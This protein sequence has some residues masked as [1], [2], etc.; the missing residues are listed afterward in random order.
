MNFSTQIPITPYKHS[1]DY[2]SVVLSIGS[3]FADHIGN[4]LA[5]YKFISY[6]NPFGI[7]FNSVSIATLIERA[8]LKRYFNAEDVFYHNECWSCYEV[9][10]ELNHTN[11]DVFL[12]NLNTQ[13]DYLHQYLSNSTHI[14][15]TYG[16]SWVYRF[17]SS[18]AI[19]ANC[20]KVKQSEFEKEL[21][22]ITQIESSIQRTLDLIQTVNPN[23]KVLFTVSPVRHIKDGFVENQRSKAHLIAGIHQILEQNN[24]LCHYF[25]SYELLMDELRDYRFYAADLLHPNTIAVDYIWERFVENTISNDVF[26]TMNAVENIQKGLSHIPFN[27]N[28]TSHLKFVENLQ[29]KIIALQKQYPHIQF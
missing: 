18:G 19:V 13:L 24:T 15:L 5:Y 14:I 21:L 25:P 3:C 1:I 20:H 22:S 2:H 6:T 8:V 4:K 9:H 29:Q 23:A 17:K 11:P 26:G 10:S 16:T 12:E 28:S 27:P 7:I